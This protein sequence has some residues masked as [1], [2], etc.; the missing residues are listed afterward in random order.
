VL[1]V[2]ERTSTGTAQQQH[3]DANPQ[4]CTADLASHAAPRRAP[5]A[6]LQNLWAR[7]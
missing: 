3:A 4:Q 1:R 7:G 5:Q 2:D 6:I